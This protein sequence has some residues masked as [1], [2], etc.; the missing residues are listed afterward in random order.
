VEAAFED[1]LKNYSAEIVREADGSLCREMHPRRS[2]A[3]EHILSEILADDR[4]AKPGTDGHPH[5]RLSKWVMEAPRDQRIKADLA[6]EIPPA[7]IH[8]VP[9]QYRI[10]YDFKNTDMVLDELLSAG[11][12][13]KGTLLDF[14]CSSGRNLAVLRRAFG[15]QLEL[16]GADPAQASIGWLNENVAGASAVVSNQNPPLPFDDG[17]FDIIIA[18]SIWTHFSPSAGRRWFAEMQ[19]IL[20]KGGHFLFSVHGPH[21]VASR[22]LLDVPRPRYDRYTGHA[23]WTRDGFLTDLVKTYRDTGY[24]FQAFKEV[25]YQPDLH[26]IENAD[27]ADW[28]LMFV[29]PEYLKSMLPEGLSVASRSVGRTG[30]R[31][32]LYIVRR[33]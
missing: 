4:L 11:V 12:E 18:K 33:D 25:G 8:F 3:C 19:R 32:D 10:F 24:Y 21:D 26:L 27:T 31:H 30:N 23:G 13:I 1:F 22:I 17:Q 29:S 20:K 14:G 16:F 15:S 7:H 28:G 6:I 9:G 2:P 5:A